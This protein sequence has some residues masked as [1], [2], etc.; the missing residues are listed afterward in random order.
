MTEGCAPVLEI[1][2][3]ANVSVKLIRDG[4]VIQQEEAHNVTVN[5]GIV[6][7]V[8]VVTG[9]TTPTFWQYVAVGTGTITPVATLTALGNEVMRVTAATATG[10]SSF[11]GDTAILTAAFT[12]AAS[13]AITEAGLFDSQNPS[14]GNML[15]WITIGTYNVVSG[16]QLTVTWQET[17]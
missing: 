12:F 4:K 6:Q 9:Q 16:D 15:G 3:K 8:K 10:T 14:S 17:L 13:Y 7:M 11:A 1:P 2:V 5:A